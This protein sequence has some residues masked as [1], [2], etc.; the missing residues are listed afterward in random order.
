MDLLPTGYEEL[1][2]LQTEAVTVTVKGKTA[3]PDFPAVAATGREGAL[4]VFSEQPYSLDVQG[5][6]REGTELSG[7]YG[8]SGTYAT[9]PMFFEQQRYELILEARE[10][11]TVGFL[12]ENRQ[13]REGVTPVGRS[14]RLLSGVISF[15]EEI[16]L[17]ELVILVDGKSSLRLTVEVFPTTLRY[18]EDYLALRQEVTREAYGLIFDFLR[19]TCQEYGQADSTGS[20]PV[21][22]LAVLRRIWEAFLGS[23]D[24]ILARP[25]HVLETTH[26]VLPG[27]KARRVDN[28]GLRWLEKHPDR[29]RPVDSRLEVSQALAVRKQVSFDTPENRMTRCILDTALE[30][31]EAFR[32]RMNR[33]DTVVAEL[34]AMAQ[35]L[36]KKILG[37]F[38]AQVKP[39][40]GKAGMSQVFAMAPGYRDLYRY[41]LMLLRGLSAAG[42]VF[43]ISL[44]DLRQLYEYWCFLKL[45]SLLKDRF[46]LVSQDIVQV[47]GTG[48]CV[49]LARGKE[50]CI[51]YRNP[52]T[53][54]AFALAWKPDA[55]VELAKQRTDMAYACV[56]APRYR[57]APD[58]GPQEGDINSLH[59][60]RDGA[61][62]KLQ[63]AYVLFPGG[64]ENFQNHPFYAEPAVESVGGLPFL[65]E[66]TGLVSQV[67]QY[68]VKDL[69]G[70]A[71]EAASLPAE[72]E[73]QLGAVNWNRR[74]VLVG[75]LRDRAQLAICLQHN[76]YHVPAEAVDE[77]AF[78]IRYVAIYQS[79]KKFGTE[80]G[81]RYYGEV[82]DC[83]L[84]PRREIREIPKNSG[85]LYYRFTIREWKCLPQPIAAKEVPIA[86]P[87][88]TNRFLL[89]HAC[90]VPELEL[91]SGEEYRL[92]YALKQALDRGRESEPGFRMGEALVVFEK[93]NINVYR[94]SRITVSCPVEDFDRQPGAVFRLL[95]KEIP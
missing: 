15:G 41:Y 82:A 61:S 38:L 69:P 30:K 42:E 40:Q 36:R 28:R 6:P 22:F 95:Q 52:R 94:D 76:F 1:I 3:Y 26:G 27:E 37:S 59:R 17:S 92:F 45:N 81:I 86:R 88:F 13:L 10:D 72:L 8:F 85:E 46:Q 74:E 34:E 4:R 91:G 65:P 80:S 33:E 21:E 83:T 55:L 24:R 32:R 20:S 79:I 51:R 5:V 29:L 90:E 9:A 64:E 25:H 11:H 19:K 50:S 77:S 43:R 58:R 54:E 31:L 39:Q 84:I 35:G 60:Y 56:F 44:K 47:R 48:L 75:S 73:A 57:L 66:A 16:G 2:Y 12:H 89:E 70:T 63:G 14:R 71:A 18:R 53:G 78:P 68:L 23:A 67:L 62:G 49:T 87:I 93:G 7:G